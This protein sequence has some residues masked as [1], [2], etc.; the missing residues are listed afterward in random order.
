M[1]LSSWITKEETV[2]CQ[3]DAKTITQTWILRTL[4]LQP[5]AITQLSIISVTG[6]AERQ[7]HCSRLLECLNGQETHTL[8]LFA[9]ICGK[10]PVLPAMLETLFS[11]DKLQIVVYHFLQKL[12]V[13]EAWVAYQNKLFLVDVRPCLQKTEQSEECGHGI[14]VFSRSKNLGIVVFICKFVTVTLRHS[15]ENLYGFIDLPKMK[16]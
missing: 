10:T 6:E 13:A 1:P 3:V 2:L 5:L 8:S 14:H 12:T 4:T 9:K 16:T 15:D 7:L 11:H